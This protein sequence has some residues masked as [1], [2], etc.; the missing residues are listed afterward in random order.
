MPNKNY[1]IY[2]II[3]KQISIAYML[4]HHTTAPLAT[5]RSATHCP[6][7]LSAITIDTI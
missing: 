6:F 1:Y 2:K 7:L 3:Q 4:S 5:N